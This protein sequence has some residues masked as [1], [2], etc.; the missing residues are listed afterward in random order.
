M[1]KRGSSRGTKLL[2]G[3][4][5]RYPQSPVPAVKHPI[6]IQGEDTVRLCM[7]TDEQIKMVK[8][9]LSK[10]QKIGEYPEQVNDVIDETLVD[11]KGTIGTQGDGW[12]WTDQGDGDGR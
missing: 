10:G 9:L 3:L 11:Y 2:E 8:K 1:A 5:H 7:M 6:I 4:R 12:G